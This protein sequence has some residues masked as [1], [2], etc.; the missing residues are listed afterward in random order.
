MAT[1][2]HRIS[3]PTSEP[4]HSFPLALYVNALTIA[5]NYNKLNWP[6]RRRR[7]SHPRAPGLLLTLT[8]RLPQSISHLTA[9]RFILN[10]KRMNA[11]HSNY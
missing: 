4:F 8:P 7:T 2:R 11:G 6:K 3:K 9:R 5:I 1:R 10:T